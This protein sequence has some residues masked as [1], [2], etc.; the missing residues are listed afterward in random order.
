MKRVFVTGASSWTGGQLVRTLAARRDVEVFAVD[1]EPPRV[2]FDA[3][4]KLLDL[5]RLAL[6]RYVLE[7]EP[8]VVVHL[9]SVHRRTEEGRTT[10]AEDRIIGALA[11][12]G[13]IERVQSVSSVIVKSDTAIY[14]SNPR[15]PSVVDESTRPKGRSS[16][17]Q[18]DLAE[19][20]RFVTGLSDR[21]PDVVITTLRFAPIFGPRIANPISRYLTLPVVPTLLGFDPRL[22]FTD[23]RDAVAVLEHSLDNPVAGTFNVAG[24]GQM[25]LSRVLRLGRRAP[26]PLPGRVFDTAL[27]TLRRT[28][29][30]VPD[31][32]SGLLKHGRVADATA[33]RTELG[34]IP[35]YTCRMTVMNAYHP[36]ISS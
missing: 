1:D 30:V 5:D 33:M 3:E 21:L 16:R 9:Q 35:R 22:Q 27:R 7:I 28:G 36:E 10:G 31:H 13:A 12:F 29:L 32:L 17:F 15:S 18:R 26:Q 23:E 34:F 24:D 8:D 2:P 4:F 11:L 20:E 19:M 25:Y 6:A 14:G